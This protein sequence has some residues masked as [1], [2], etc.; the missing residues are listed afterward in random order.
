MCRSSWQVAD[1]VFTALCVRLCSIIISFSVASGVIK[2]LN[3]LCVT[4]MGQKAENAAC[5][6]KATAET[7]QSTA[8]IP[9]YIHLLAIPLT[10]L[11]VVFCFPR[12]AAG[13]VP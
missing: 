6:I 9:L 7:V 2:G 3:I 13:S 11:S 1:P 4:Q 5:S 8:T 10:H 12:A